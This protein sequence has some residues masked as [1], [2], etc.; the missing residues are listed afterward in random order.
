MSAHIII[1]VL[2]R[3]IIIHNLI[4]P[5]GLKEGSS[6]HKITFISTLTSNI[7]ELHIWDIGTRIGQVFN[8]R[9]E[10]VRT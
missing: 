4:I 6:N 5:V 9:T 7:V 8:N 1:I 2:Q 3:Q 10:P